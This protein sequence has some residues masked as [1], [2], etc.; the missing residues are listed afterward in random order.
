MKGMTMTVSATPG[1]DTDTDPTTQLNTNTTQQF[2]LAYNLDSSDDVTTAS[3]DASIDQ[4]NQIGTLLPGTVP[5]IIQSNSN[6]TV[7]MAD[8]D[9]RSQR[10]GDGNREQHQLHGTSQPDRTARHK[11]ARNG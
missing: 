4:S 6:E 5:D 7:Q 2:A 9:K 11:C 10:R 3:N 1:D 8:C